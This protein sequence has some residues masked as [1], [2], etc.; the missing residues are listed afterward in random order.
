[1][2]MTQ[3][4]T[5]QIGTYD[6]VHTKLVPPQRRPQIVS[7]AA[8][9]GRLDTGLNCKVT[10]VSAPAGFGKTTLIADWLRRHTALVEQARGSTSTG[11][12]DAPDAT[13]TE[14][15]KAAWLALDAG[16][17]DP[18]RFWRYVL[19]ACQVIDRDIGVSTHNL[20]RVSARPDY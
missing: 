11:N 15:F 2:R 5:Q 20:L 6:L 8:L 13:G 9:L 18:T 4:Q 10:L 1:M 12:G 7:R 16:D 17:N 19:A 3:Y 14:H